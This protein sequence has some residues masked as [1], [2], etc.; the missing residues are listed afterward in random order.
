MEL[1]GSAVWS[2]EASLVHQPQVF[3]GMNPLAER[4][5]F[6]RPVP[7][8]NAFTCLC[9]GSS[10]PFVTRMKERAEEGTAMSVPWS[11]YY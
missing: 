6:N 11:P 10:D 3:A 4:C 2:H 1:N 7:L 5:G 8:S 9:L